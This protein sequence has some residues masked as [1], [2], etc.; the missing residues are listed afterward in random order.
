MFTTL[1][2]LHGFPFVAVFKVTCWFHVGSNTPTAKPEQTI[3][4]KDLE[5]SDQNHRC[6]DYLERNLHFS[7]GWLQTISFAGLLRQAAVARDMS[8]HFILEGRF[9]WPVHMCVHIYIYTYIYIYIYIHIYIYNC[10][11]IYIYILY[12]YIYIY[13]Y[14]YTYYY[15]YICIIYENTT[16]QL[17]MNIHIHYFGSP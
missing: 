3:S 4:A 9:T 7:L 6:Y 2:S 17:C 15:I 14:I 8:S 12:V 5:R 16:V 13:M 11:C 10:M 1:E